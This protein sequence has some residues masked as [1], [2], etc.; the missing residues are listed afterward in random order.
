MTQLRYETSLIIHQGKKRNHSQVLLT[1][2]SEWL[3]AEAL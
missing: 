2:N 3:I 1:G